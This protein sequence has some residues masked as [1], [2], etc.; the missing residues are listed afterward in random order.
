MSLYQGKRIKQ[1]CIV[2]VDGRELPPRTDLR[3]HSPTGFEWGYG[4]SGPSQLA[5]AILCWH[6]ASNEQRALSYYPLFKESIIANINADN[7]KM[8]SG[9]IEA[10]L[11]K[12]ETQE[13]S[14]HGYATA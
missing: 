4:G 5:L 7:W 10:C 11:Q 3:N 6:C 12:F 2:T 8:T 9:Y 14:G 1:G 13:D